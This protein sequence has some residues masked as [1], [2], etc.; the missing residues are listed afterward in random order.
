[1]DVLSLQLSNCDERSKIVFGLLLPLFLWCHLSLLWLWYSHYYFC[2]IRPINIRI[3]LVASILTTIPSCL[4]QLRKTQIKYKFVQ[5]NLLVQL[6]NCFTNCNFCAK[7]HLCLVW[8]NMLLRRNEWFALLYKHH[9]TGLRWSATHNS[10][11]VGGFTSYNV[12]DSTVRPSK[13]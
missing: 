10:I 3:I 13:H 5:I 8:L 11:T 9:C 7:L 12:N 4:K 2:I 1:M 6:L